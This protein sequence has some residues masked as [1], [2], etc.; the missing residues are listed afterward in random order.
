M[1]DTSPESM[2]VYQKKALALELRLRKESFRSI[3]V[4]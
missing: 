2:A 3:A 4:Q 1:G